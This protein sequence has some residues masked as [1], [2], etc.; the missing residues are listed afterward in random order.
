MDFIDQIKGLSQQVQELKD[1]VKT[2]EATKHAF[3]MPLISA[4]GYNVFNPKEVCPEF[5]A[6]VP[7][8]KAEKV[9]YAI[10]MDGQPII[11]IECKS[12]NENI[13]KPQ[14]LSQLFRYFAVTSVKFSIL[15]NGIVY[16]FYT[17]IDK[18]HVMDDKPFFEF[19][20]LQ[21]NESTINELKRFSKASFNA[22]EMGD[23]ARNLLYTKE[24]KRLIAEQL[25]SPS[26]DFV[27]FFAKQVHSGSFVSSVVDKFSELVKQSL[28]D[29][30]NDRITERLVS[31]I[32]LPDLSSDKITSLVDLQNT[33]SRDD[34][35]EKEILVITDEE[36][37]GYYIIKSILRESID[38][39]R[40][41]YKKTRHYLGVNLDDKASKTICR[42]WFSG[43][44]RYISIF[45]VDNKEVKKLI[46]NL[47]EIYSMAQII[48]DRGLFLIQNSSVKM[49]CVE[50]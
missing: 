26:P 30:I 2:E 50:G 17:D 24:I 5:T 41:S 8:V 38:T 15:T 46:N 45:D 19:N 1:S 27:K 43:Q 13:D 37:E 12:W 10:M 16:R 33:D 11:L 34:S 29:F 31:A 48:R 6:D 28:K 44:Q 20:I 49:H 42:L 47:D 7:G 22:D 3:V 32:N 4:L 40:L 35:S 21:F 25:N 14:H 18:K 36:K 23:I 9:D 39:S